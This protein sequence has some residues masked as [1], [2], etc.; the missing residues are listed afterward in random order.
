M[1]A[2][3]ESRLMGGSPALV[4]PQVYCSSSVSSRSLRFLVELDLALRKVTPLVL[5]EQQQG[6]LTY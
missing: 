2:F 4:G 5:E 6:I 3:A 1:A